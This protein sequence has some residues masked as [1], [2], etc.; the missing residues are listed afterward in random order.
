MGNK[1]FSQGIVV[2][3]ISFVDRKMVTVK[4]IQTILRAKPHESMPVL[5]DGKDV[6]LG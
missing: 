1:I 2:M 4:T 3:R 5:Q 6:I